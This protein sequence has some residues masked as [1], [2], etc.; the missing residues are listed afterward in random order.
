MAY[1][2]N[3]LNYGHI[4][5]SIFRNGLHTT[6]K[7]YGIDKTTLGCVKKFATFDEYKDFIAKKSREA[8]ERR[9]QKQRERMNSGNHIHFR[10]GN[11]IEFKKPAP[12]TP[13]ETSAELGRAKTIITNVEKE[14]KMEKKI[15]T[16]KFEMFKKAETTPVEKVSPLLKY[17]PMND[18]RINIAI[19]MARVG[20]MKNEI[21]TKLGYPET[22]T[23]MYHISKNPKYKEDFERALKEGREKYLKNRGKA[24]KAGRDKNAEVK[25][26]VK[27]APKV[28]PKVETKPEPKVEPK[29]VAKAKPEPK[30]EPKPE[31]REEYVNVSW[32]PDFMALKHAYK[33]EPV[34]KEN[35]SDKLTNSASFAI[36][37]LSIGVLAILLAQAAQII[38]TALK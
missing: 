18:E 20:C 17:E 8:Y 3:S 15:D 2:I 16:P 24:S 13:F 35:V 7:A 25:Q 26:V 28:E 21:A 4:R 22:G 27:P 14:E 30:V 5:S 29:P 6:S 36:R 9:L 12:N 23:M 33:E 10:D 31:F 34:Q 11:K 19:G 38:I 32:N 37:A 1:K